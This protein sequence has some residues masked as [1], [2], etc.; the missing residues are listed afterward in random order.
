MA[1]LVGTG[2]AALT[3]AGSVALLSRGPCAV[4]ARG[5]ARNLQSGIEQ[6][7]QRRTST[8]TVRDWRTA[9]YA[10]APRDLPGAARTDEATGCPALTP[11]RRGRVPSRLGLLMVVSAVHGR[12]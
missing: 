7:C 10:S 5:A 4:P 6:R 2:E 11:D 8:C 12:G 1:L 9:L 3:L